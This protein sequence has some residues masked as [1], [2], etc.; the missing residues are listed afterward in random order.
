MERN[1]VVILTAAGSGKRLGY[2]LPKSLVPLN[3]GSVSCET[4]EG[5]AN[6]PCDVVCD[7]NSNEG[8][9]FS[10][11][12]C[13]DTHDV[14][15]SNS[16]EVTENPTI[17]IVE[18]ALLNILQV[19]NLCRV[20]VTVPVGFEQDFREVLL[21]NQCLSPKL[22]S[23]FIVLVEGG[24]SR[25][26][27]VGR[28]LSYLSTFLPDSGVALDDCVVLV[29][30]AARCFTPVGVYDFLVDSFCELSKGVSSFPSNIG[31]VPVLPM[32]DTVKSIECFEDCGLQL[33]TGV[34]RSKLFRVQTPQVFDFP[35][36][37]ALHEEFSSL[38]LSEDTAFTDDASMLDCKG[39]K[40]VYVKGDDLS[41]KITTVFD[42]M[43]AKFLYSSR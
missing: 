27:S 11:D 12:T 17:T 33:A 39:G 20:V 22:L 28:G 9:S 5:L 38:G 3:G 23:D 18:Q 36:I 19:S 34:D 42:L 30:D 2:G 32:V 21:S 15:F 16:S 24:V 37:F 26:E 7:F 13:V 41:F 31:V 35:T 1:V 43:F 40:V 25:Q 8:V 6:L 29:H 10:S 14:S 4:T